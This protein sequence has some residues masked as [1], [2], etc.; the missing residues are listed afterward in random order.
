VKNVHRARS[1]MYPNSCRM[2][3]VLTG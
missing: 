3:L 2:S 1:V